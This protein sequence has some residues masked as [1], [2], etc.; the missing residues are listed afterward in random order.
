MHPVSPQL[1]SQIFNKERIPVI[2]S[3]GHQEGR[4]KKNHQ[5][6]LAF[7]APEA[8]YCHGLMFCCRTEVAKNA[9]D[10]QTEL[11]SAVWAVVRVAT[12]EDLEKLLV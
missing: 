6:S 10:M 9:R 11:S 12:L 4:R 3:I 8:E 1:S 7:S 5:L 2:G